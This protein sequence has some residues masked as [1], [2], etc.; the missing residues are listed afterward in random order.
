MQVI[1]NYSLNVMFGDQSIT[2][3]PQAINEFTITQDIDTLLPMLKLSLRDATGQLTNMIP[4]DK[5]INKVTVGI[6]ASTD[7][8]NLNEFHFTVKRRRSETGLLYEVQGVLDVP[9]C[10]TDQKC[11]ALTGNVRSSIQNIAYDEMQAKSVDIG[12]S[13]NFDK[14]LIQPQWTNATFL[15]WL[16]K[17][18]L[19]KNG[20]AGYFTFFYNSGSVQTFCMKTLDELLKSNVTYN[21]IVSPFSLY[22]HFP[23]LSY[24]I[25]D[26]S[27]LLADMGSAN[28]DYVYFDY[29]TGEYVKSTVNISDV[30]ALSPLHYVDVDRNTG[31]QTIYE[32]GRTN[33][34][35]DSFEG[36]I[37]GLFYKKATEFVE[38]WATTWGLE[39]IAPGDIV[40][41]VFGDMLKQDKLFAYQHSGLWLVKR[42]VHNIGST[43]TTNLL[44]ARS[45]CDTNVVN[46]L[47]KA[48]NV[49]NK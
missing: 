26:N 24:E 3:P 14:T 44:L 28:Q 5:G 31:S 20:E 6:S 42:V 49:V 21:L 10:I 48:E 2:L 4:F 8:S 9:Q 22:D 1:G 46:S 12:A 45:G 36:K 32:N 25:Y 38:M 40:K 39:D 7:P 17:N 23:I 35:N 11:R 15:R 19:G 37:K 27:Q 18:L 34:F 29:E 41:V 33:D 30:P 47:I 43:F 16:S 13:L